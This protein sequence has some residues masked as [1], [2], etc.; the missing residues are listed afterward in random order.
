MRKFI[1]SSV[2]IIVGAF[3]GPNTNGNCPVKGIVYS[4][5]DGIACTPASVSASVRYDTNMN[6]I[7]TGTV[8]NGTGCFW[9]GRVNGVDKIVYRGGGKNITTIEVNMSYAGGW[10]IS[11]TAQVNIAPNNKGSFSVSF[12]K[13]TNGGTAYLYQ[14]SAVRFSDGSIY[15]VNETGALR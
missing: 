5:Q 14:V 7:V 2:I 4:T 10:N 15:R 13:V 3:C 12:P 6:P 1:I 9:E 8:S 11:K